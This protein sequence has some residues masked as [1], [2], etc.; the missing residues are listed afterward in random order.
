MHRPNSRQSA[1][2]N[3]SIHILTAYEAGIPSSVMRYKLMLGDGLHARDADAHS[4]EARLACNILN[5]M[6]EP[7][8]PA[9]FAVRM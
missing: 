9:S 2:A 6:I 1:P 5:R 4:V 3:A 8:M 7:G